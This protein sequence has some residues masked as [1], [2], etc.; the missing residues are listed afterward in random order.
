MLIAVAGVVRETLPREKRD[1]HAAEDDAQSAWTTLRKPAFLG[2]C[3][4]FGF[5]FATMMAYIAVSAVRVPGHD[6]TEQWWVRNRI[7]YQRLCADGRQRRI[8]ETRRVTRSREP[9]AVGLSIIGVATIAFAVLAFTGAPAWSP[10][11]PLFVIVGALG[12]VFGNATAL[13]MSAVSSTPAAP[14]R[15][16]APCS[17]AS[18]Q[19]SRRW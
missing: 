3:C 10:A 15:S 6:R 12:L 4:A 2:Y 5:A 1:A 18:R 17:S 7:R 9:A 11:A 13:A 19:S 8:R 14:R 16:S